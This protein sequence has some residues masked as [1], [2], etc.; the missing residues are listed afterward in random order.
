MQ[1]T[2]LLRR[3]PWIV[4]GGRT[5]LFLTFQAFIALLFLVLGSRQAWSSASAWWTLFVTF[6]NFTCLYFLVRLFKADNRKYRDIFKFE[7]PSLKKDT[8][9]F[10]GSL[11][12]II[13]ISMAPN[14]LLAKVLFGGM[15]IPMGMFLLPLPK[16]AIYSV[17]LVLFPLTQA[18]VEL[19]FYFLYCMPKIEEKT[20]NA[21]LAYC[22]C[23]VFLGFQ[24][25]MIPFLP[26]W[27]F[28]LWRALM[29]LPF[30]FFVGA[31]LRWRPRMLPYLALLH[32]FMD[33]SAAIMYV[34][35]VY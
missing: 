24:H 9:V 4:M 27:R 28:I 7:R 20:D 35:G 16:W 6:T 2:T 29:F 8:L 17:A 3:S 21:V 31:L 26:D 19:A 14:L 10:A 5:L 12:L 13:P 1:V 25:S 33:F 11:L 34:T 15:Q 23:C 18:L 22:S 32:L 30:A